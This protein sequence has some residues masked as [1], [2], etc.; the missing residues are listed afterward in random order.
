[1][2]LRGKARGVL[3]SAAELTTAGLTTAGEQS[4]LLDVRWALGDDRGREE[5]LGGHLP[6][7]V[8]VDLESELADPPDPA[9]GRHPVPS[10]QRLQ[11]VARR[12][13]VHADRPVVAYDD[14][15]AVAGI[16]VAVVGRA[17]ATG[18]DGRLISRCGRRSRRA[19]RRTG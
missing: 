13:G 7:A 16:V 1:V 6:G 18:G 14:T 9:L 17:G 19:A 3:V 8:F 2:L 10:L 5:Y 15:G 4:V 11:A 12:W